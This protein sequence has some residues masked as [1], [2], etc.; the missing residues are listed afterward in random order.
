MTD[1][2]ERSC[3]WQMSATGVLSQVTARPIHGTPG[4]RRFQADGRI[5]DNVLLDV[6]EI[7]L[8]ALIV[9]VL[10]VVRDLIHLWF[11]PRAEVIR[12]G[13]VNRALP[14]EESSLAKARHPPQGP[15][16]RKYGDRRPPAYSA[17]ALGSP[18]M[19]LGRLGPV[20]VTHP[21]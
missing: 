16:E 21:V 9:V 1:L 20:L 11:R 7:C 6:L 8:R 18:D 13:L 12:G 10:A 2:R 14:R 15:A 19:T 4:R 17:L 5:C 3:I